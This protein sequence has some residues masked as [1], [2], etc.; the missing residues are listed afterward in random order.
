M[1]DPFFPGAAPELGKRRA[2]KEPQ[3]EEK[4]NISQKAVRSLGTWEA[5]ELGHHQT[6]QGL[7]PWPSPMK[8]SMPSLKRAGLWGKSPTGVPAPSLELQGLG[9]TYLSSFFSSAK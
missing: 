4:V 8:N 5:G 6:S 3:G 9:A 7:A 2:R 1:Q